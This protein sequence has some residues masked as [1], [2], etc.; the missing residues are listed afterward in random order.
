MEERELGP[1]SDEN[2]TR[3]GTDA[4]RRGGGLGLL[5]GQLGEELARRPTDRA[6]ELQ[7]AADPR[8]DRMRDLFRGAEETQ[9]AG[10]VEERLVERERLDE[11][12]ELAEDLLHLP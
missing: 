1:G 5:R 10:D 8:P 9:G 2:D 12:C 4:G 3:P 6:V 7:L 11:R